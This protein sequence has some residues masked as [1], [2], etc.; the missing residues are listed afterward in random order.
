MKKYKQVSTLYIFDIVHSE[1]IRKLNKKS[2]LKNPGII[3]LF[4]IKIEHKT[5][6][7][8]T[9]STLILFI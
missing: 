1:N 8:I 7:T 3:S 2:K 9:L 5:I 4:F 6:N